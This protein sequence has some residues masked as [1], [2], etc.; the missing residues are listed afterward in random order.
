MSLHSTAWHN[1]GQRRL[2]ENRKAP[3][4]W[5]GSG[6]SHLIH[7]EF[8]SDCWAFRNLPLWPNCRD[9]HIQLQDPRF[10]H[11]V[12]NHFWGIAD[13]S[14]TPW[15]ACLRNGYLSLSY[16]RIISSEWA[17]RPS[18]TPPR[19]KELLEMYVG[20]NVES[21]QQHWK[22]RTSNYGERKDGWETGERRNRMLG[23][24]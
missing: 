19:S 24:G 14:H 2:Q 16:C 6:H 20:Q 9:S 21:G 18:P 13:R 11:W 17:S 5:A 15:K 4:S 1:H 22:H 7:F 10:R 3:R 8:V 12:G 23:E